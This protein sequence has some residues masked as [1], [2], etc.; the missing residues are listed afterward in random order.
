MDKEVI[1]NKKKTII[2]IIT[3]VV[4]AL[5]SGIYL[6]YDN[7]QYGQ[8]LSI[9]ILTVK[10]S[11]QLLAD[12]I[13]WHLKEFENPDI[14]PV[15]VKRYGFD[16][17]LIQAKYI[18][19]YE[20]MALV[21]NVRTEYVNR[22]DYFVLQVASDYRNICFAELFTDEQKSVEIAVFKDKLKNL[23]F[24]FQEFF[25]NYESMSFW[26]RCFTNWRHE[27]ALLSEQVKLS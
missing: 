16:Y 21:D 23:A 13:E 12:A 4:L 20:D 5:L 2:L 22:C 11:S 15:N 27:Q 24:N 14:D 18:F 3:L 19:K 1:M 9:S 25:E 7:Y 8:K 17:N 10:E 26:E 6:V